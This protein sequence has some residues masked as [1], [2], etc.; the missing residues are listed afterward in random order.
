MSIEQSIR[1]IA[2]KDN[3]VGIMGSSTIFAIIISPLSIFHIIFNLYVS[4]GVVV[5]QINAPGNS[6]MLIHSLVL[7]ENP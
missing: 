4:E 1:E 7:P 6:S 5:M 3:V 2:K